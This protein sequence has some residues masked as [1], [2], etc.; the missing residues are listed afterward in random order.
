[1]WP[2]IF[3]IPTY[4]I[5]YIGGMVAHF[6][7]TRRLART[8]N[9]SLKISY[10]VSMCYFL[11]MTVGAGLL[12]D[13]WHD[14]IRTARVFSPQRYFEG[15][16]WGGPLAYLGLAVPMAWCLAID[17]RAAVDMTALSLPV[18]MI[19]AKIGCLSQGCCYGKP[20]ALPW[21]IFFPHETPT[22]PAGVALHPTQVYEVLVLAI[23]G[24]TLLKLDR[25]RW[26]GTYLLWFLLL[27]GVGRPLTEF[28]RG[29]LK[30]SWV[31]PLSA[32]QVVCLAAAAAAVLGLA[33]LRSNGMKRG[34]D[35][36]ADELR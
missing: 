28:H 33:F 25:Q 5:F 10:L 4:A 27:Y 24:I 16:F 32:S 23:V 8:W 12:Y 21:A 19:L 30:G 34:S 20:C 1:M 15:G 13:L 31:G 11:G 9:I 17:K 18:P 29:D 7:I 26:K 2:K 6:A 3:G 14:T 35:S 22:A 36:T